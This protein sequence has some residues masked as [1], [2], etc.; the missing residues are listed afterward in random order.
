MIHPILKYN[1]MPTLQ[2]VYIFVK[3]FFLVSSDI[4]RHDDCITLIGQMF[5]NILLIVLY[6]LFYIKTTMCD[7]NC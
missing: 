1:H 7:N 4:R 6:D 5:S 2:C 3:S